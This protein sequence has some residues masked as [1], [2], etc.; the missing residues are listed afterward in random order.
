MELTR[1]ACPRCHVSRVDQLD[2]LADDGHGNK[3]STLVKHQDTSIPGGHIPVLV[4]HATPH[5]ALHGQVRSAG[6][7]GQHRRRHTTSQ[8][9]LGHSCYLDQARHAICNRSTPC[10]R[11]ESDR[12]SD[13][14][15]K[16][17]MFMGFVP[18]PV[19]HSVLGKGQY[20]VKR[21][22]KPRRSAAS[23]RGRNHGLC[24]TWVERLLVQATP[25]IWY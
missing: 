16:A 4:R 12:E 11:Y 14:V 21:R 1:V 25:R 22:V 15:S 5:Q 2:R 18:C 9:K 3:P 7:V 23:P 8:N 19:T 17:I 6:Y 20:G 10:D 13:W 24:I